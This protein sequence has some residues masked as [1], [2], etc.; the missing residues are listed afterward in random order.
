MATQTS[1]KTNPR[2]DR[3]TVVALF[4]SHAE[5]QK[6]VRDLKAAGF[7]PQTDFGLISTSSGRSSSAVGPFDAPTMAWAGGSNAK[8]YSAYR[9]FDPR[10]G[11]E[12]SK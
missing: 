9:F 1:R 10:G 2:T 5:A 7:S 12:P 8:D 3:E 11:S 6:A 4:H